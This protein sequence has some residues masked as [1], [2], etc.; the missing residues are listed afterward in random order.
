MACVWSGRASWPAC[1]SRVAG[2]AEAGDLPLDDPIRVCTPG[3]PASN[4]FAMRPKEI[5]RLQLK[6]PYIPLRVHVSDG[7]RYD[8]RHPEMMTVTSTLAFIGQEPFD[9]GLAARL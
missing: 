8:V 5:V 6:R 3:L 4:R 7:S 9:Y 2:Q 1:G